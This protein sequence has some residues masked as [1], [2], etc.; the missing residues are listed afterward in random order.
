ME[1]YTFNGG[2]EHEGF[3]PPVDYREYCQEGYWVKYADA[4]QAVADADV[5][6]YLDGVEWG[7]KHLSKREEWPMSWDAKFPG[8]KAQALIDRTESIRAREA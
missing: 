2:W 3:D 5:K 6:A 8:I 4:V 7:I 1:R